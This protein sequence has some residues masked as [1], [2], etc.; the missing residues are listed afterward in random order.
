MWLLLT[1]Y[2]ISA[3]LLWLFVHYYIKKAGSGDLVLTFVPFINS[4]GVIIAFVY[5]L[6]DIDWEKLASKVFKVDNK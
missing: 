1:I 2:L 4:L 5:I 6:M 3:S